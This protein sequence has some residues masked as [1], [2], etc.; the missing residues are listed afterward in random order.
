[1]SL[2]AG[3]LAI[4]KTRLSATDLG[5][6]VGINPHRSA[7]DVRAEKLYDLDPIEDT[8]AMAIGRMFEP[9]IIAWV[10]QVLGVSPIYPTPTVI[11]PKCD[12][13]CST[14]DAAIQERNEGIEGKTAGIEAG[15]VYGG[16]W[17]EPGSA[18]VPECYLVQVQTQMA[19][20]EWDVVHLG[21][22][23][24]GRGRVLY[25]IERDDAM[26]RDILDFAPWWWA[27]H[28]TNGEPITDDDGAIQR[29]G[30]D[31]LKRIRRVPQSEREIDPALFDAWRAA[32]DTRKQSEDAEELAK[33]A[34]LDSIG[35]GD[36]ASVGGHTIA[37]FYEQSR[38]TLDA[39][40]LAMLFPEAFAACRKESKFR[41][42]R[43]TK[44][45][46][47]RGVVMA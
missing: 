42:L 30:L 31:T 4:R 7:A 28:V 13:I 12:R 43:A 6:I 36:A 46:K 8:E 33:R 40:R 41:V 22:V 15:R 29:P 17:G 23:I 37:T 9:G 38:K 5:A 34:L 1:M 3:Q 32:A 10:G 25:A 19:C 21:A 2:T 24:A 45:G 18:D 14:P 47:A 44:A 16:E 26:I 20:M 11:H 39:D 35:D 27:K